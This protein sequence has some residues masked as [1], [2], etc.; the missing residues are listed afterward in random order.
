MKNFLK[1][2]VGS[3]TGSKR[4]LFFAA[5][6]RLTA[7][8]IAI[9]AI[10]L[11]VFSAV[12]YATLSQQLYDSIDGRFSSSEDQEEVF[13]KTKDGV[14]TTIVVADMIVLILTAAGS[15]VLAGKTLKPIK[16]ALDAQKRFTAD[17]SHELRTPLAIIKT[18]SEVAL[19]NPQTTTSELRESLSS[20]LEEID[21]MTAM[22]ESL[23]ALSSV[24]HHGDVAMQN[25]V[26]LIQIAEHVIAKLRPLA[27]QKH[28]R[29]IVA[30]GDEG[31]ILGNRETLSR[32]LYNLLQNSIKYTPENGKITISVTASN[33]LLE[34]TVADTGAGIPTDALPH[35]FSRFYKANSARAA[36]T[37]GGAGLGLSIVKSIVNQHNGIITVESKPAQGTT[38]T[39]NFKLYGP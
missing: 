28:L 10:I 26:S 38:V 6:L 12:L 29:I 3:V 27:E 39:I 20:N 16:E 36:N 7:Y 8:Y 30:R 4:S 31:L 34:L 23:L 35:I 18:E 24:D 17:A 2:S 11:L 13:L 9:M 32:M 25:P 14:Q 1:Q 21:R 15:Y 22:V 5:R 33:S 37:T 19:K